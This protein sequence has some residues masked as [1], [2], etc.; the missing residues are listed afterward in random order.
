MPIYEYQC[1]A[2]GH[3]LEKL[4]R[5]SAAPL[6]DCPA[7]EAPELNR[8]VSAAGF[9]LAGGGWYETDFKTGG[10]KKNLAGDSGGG[11]ASS[12]GGSASGDGAAA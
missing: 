7:C 1:K 11:G 6:T 3:R 8:L 5:M 12:G 9:R 10:T 2:C 4:Q